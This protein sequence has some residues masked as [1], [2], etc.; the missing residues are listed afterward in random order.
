MVF[1]M[2]GFPLAYPTLAPQQNRHGDNKNS[3]I[4]GVGYARSIIIEKIF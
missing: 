3:G 2:F 1:D 4:V